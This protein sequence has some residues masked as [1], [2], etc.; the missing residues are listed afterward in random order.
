MTN[1]FPAP[2]LA[3]LVQEK[4]PEIMA[5]VNQKK[6]AKLV[7]AAK[8]VLPKDWKVSFAVQ[9]HSTI[10]ATINEA[11][12]AV[13]ADFIGPDED[14]LFV[15]PYHLSLAW[16]GATA[17]TLEKLIAALNTDNHDNSDSMTDYFDVGH[18]V[19]IQFGKWNKPTKFI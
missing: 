6:K 16:Q 5:W 18:Y 9:N 19:S 15:N 10:V 2:I 1:L 8:A 3:L 17:E 14:G 4:E 7:K 13:K 11:P 12:E